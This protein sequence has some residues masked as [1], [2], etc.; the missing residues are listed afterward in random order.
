SR[1]SDLQVRLRLTRCRAQFYSPVQAHLAGAEPPHLAQPIEGDRQRDSADPGSERGIAPKVTQP[2]EHPDERV[3]GVILC[4]VRISGDA[5]HQAVDPLDVRVVQLARGGR[6]T[7]LYTG[8]QKSVV[9]RA[10]VE[11]FNASQA[12]VV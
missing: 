3:L 9:H 12:S 5:I 6:V 8:D 2:L 7:G 10:P 11:G 4:L 1:E